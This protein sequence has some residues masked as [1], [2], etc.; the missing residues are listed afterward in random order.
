MANG[1]RFEL[2]V[3]WVNGSH[4]IYSFRCYDDMIEWILTNR[5]DIQLCWERC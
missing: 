1:L 2:T 4:G 3:I 5:S